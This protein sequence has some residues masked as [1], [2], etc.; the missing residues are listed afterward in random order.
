MPNYR[1]TLAR[2]GL[3]F[4]APDDQPVLLAAERA[5]IDLPNSCRNGT[6]RTCLQQL[7]EGS[8]AYRIEWPGVS[9]DEQRAGCFLP[10]CA[11]PR[12]DLLIR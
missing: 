2:K 7:A 5:G 3:S 12:S 1:V 4:E 8:V 10:C 9:S 11:Y 6:C